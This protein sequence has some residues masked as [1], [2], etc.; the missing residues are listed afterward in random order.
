MATWATSARLGDHELAHYRRVTEANLDAASAL[1][2]DGDVVVVH[3]PQPR[4]LVPS[5]VAYGCARD[6]DVPRGGG[7]HERRHALRLGLP[8]AV[9]R[10]RARL[11]LHA[12][13]VRVGGPRSVSRPADPAVHRPAVAEERPITPESRDAIMAVAG[14]AQPV[15]GAE[16]GLRAARWIT[17][18]R[19]AA[20]RR[21]RADACA[22]RR[23]DRDAGL[24]MGPPEGSGRRA[25][26]LRAM[27]GSRMRT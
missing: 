19:R 24:A 4:G 17:R 5:L 18:P 13:G 14:L 26:R 20:C 22:A 15:A 3:D 16:P 6:L 27:P 21:P 1:V 23:P 2:R 25:P 9:R 10:R 8:A 7:R 12:A 11:R